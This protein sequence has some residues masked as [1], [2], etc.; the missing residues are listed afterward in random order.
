MKGT[1]DN[2]GFH[3]DGQATAYQLNQYVQKAKSLI[4]LNCQEEA[5]MILLDII[6]EIGED[7]EEYNDHD[8]DLGSVCQDT[9]GLVVEM[10]ETGLPDDILSNVTEEINELIKNSNYAN[11]DLGD[12]NQIVFSISQKAANFDNGIRIFDEALKIE[13]DSFRSASLVKSKLK[14]LQSADKKEEIEKVISDYLYLPEIRK[15]RLKELTSEKQYEKALAMIDEGITLAQK[16]GHSGTVTDWKDEALSVY[17]LMENPEK[18]IELAEDLFVTGRDRMKYYRA[19]KNFTPSEKWADYLDN[20]L[21]KSIKQKAWGFGDVLAKIYIAEEYW[22]RLMD[23]V[24]KNIQFGGY[25]SLKAYEPYL[26]SRYPERM[27]AFYRKQITEYAA[28]NMGRGHYKYVADVLKTMKQYP[29]GDKVAN[30]LLAYFKSVYSSR[31]AMM[32]ELRK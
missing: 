26:K 14:L 4:K 20:V 16:K 5:M 8:G 19:L 31:R 24:E 12:L 25:N 1:Y 32:E 18:V 27:L 7:Y 15:I 21:F 22:D 30:T 10:I 28:K 3:N 23:Y 9:V 13:P 17:M 29:D 11:Y 2:Y 6:R